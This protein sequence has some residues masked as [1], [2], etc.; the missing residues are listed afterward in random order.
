MSIN[1]LRGQSNVYPNGDH[2]VFLNVIGKLTNPVSLNG[3]IT[4]PLIGDT[5]DIPLNGRISYVDLTVFGG[6]ENI[7]NLI[8]KYEVQLATIRADFTT[9]TSDRTVITIDRI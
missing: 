5:L 7:I 1:T 9:V 2:E 3:D 4:L 8:G 6:L